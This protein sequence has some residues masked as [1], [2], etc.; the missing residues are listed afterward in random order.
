M[1]ASARIILPLLLIVF[2]EVS[3]F[4]TWKAESG[5]DLYEREQT[6]ARVDLIVES[7]IDSMVDDM[8]DG[9]DITAADYKIDAMT[10][11]GS[12]W[13]PVKSILKRSIPPNL[14]ALY[15][16]YKN[17]KDVKKFVELLKTLKKIRDEAKKL[18][19]NWKTYLK[20]KGETV[21]K[22]KLEYF[23]VK[24]AKYMKYAKFLKQ[25][26]T[27][28]K[29]KKDWKGYA[30]KWMKDQVKKWLK[31]KLAKYKDKWKGFKSKFKKFRGAWRRRRRHG[32]RRRHH[33]R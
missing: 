29:E 8:F 25:V 3:A 7:T 28:R 31:E 19:E 30:K 24:Y 6:D 20:T 2:D 23:K 21:L 17:R 18:G 9:R 5:E 15:K 4:S 27:L 16:L 1:M 33:W 22:S 13:N 11:L 32:G 10:E 26:W 14:K 12:E